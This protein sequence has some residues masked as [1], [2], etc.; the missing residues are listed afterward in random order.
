MQVYALTP[1][2]QCGSEELLI[3]PGEPETDANPTGWPAFA[4]CQHCGHQPSD[5]EGP[6]SEKDED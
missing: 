5:W 4:E 6:E 1:C 3:T 2:P